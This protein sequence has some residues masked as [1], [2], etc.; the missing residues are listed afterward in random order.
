MTRACSK[1]GFE[2]ADDIDFCARCGEY[3]RWELSGT[4]RLPPEEGPVDATRAAGSP[5]APQET[6]PYPVSE[7]GQEAAGQ[8]PLLVALRLPE[9]ESA[10]GEVA[11]T[12][13]AG[14][15]TNVIAFLRNQS[16]IVDNYDLSVE[17]L[18][19][20][21]WSIAPT[22]VY[23]VPY[24]A[25][26]GEYEQDVTITFHPPRTPEAE[27]R[28]W[29]IRVVAT[30]RANA[31]PAGGAAATLEIR[32]YH[33]LEAEMRPEIASGRR[34]ARY[35]IALRNR[36]NAAV[37]VEL[38]TVD[39]EGILRFKFE[40]QRFSIEPGRRNGSIFG[41]SAAKGVLFG[42]SIQR[43][44]E[45]ASTVTGSDVGAPPKSG[46]FV[47]KAWVP[48]WAIVVG[49]LLV[50]GAIAAYLLWPHPVT[51]PSLKG[52]EVF[53]AQQLLDQAGLELGNRSEKA[54]NGARPGTILTQ[55]PQAG[56]E[57]DSGDEVSILVAVATD[58][59]VV[60]DI[61]GLSLA[62]ADEALS[63]V[64]FSLGHAN[65][66]P[67][68]P[69]HSRIVS[70][71]PVAGAV[72]RKGRGVDVYFG[73]EGEG[74]DGARLVHE[75]VTSA[76]DAEA[77]A[78]ATAGKPAGGNVEVP[79]L[80]ESTRAR[81]AR[82]LTQASLTPVA[83]L[84]YTADV[85]AGQLVT[86]SPEAGTSV[87]PWTNVAYF[88][89]APYPELAFEADGDL[90]TMSGADGT[91]TGTLMKSREFEGHLAWNPTGTTLAFRRGTT[92]QGGQIWLVARDGSRPARQLTSAGFDDRRPAFSPDGNVIAFVRGPLEQQPPATRDFDLC[93]VKARGGEPACI[94]DEAN[95]VHR[96]TWAPDGH[97]ILVTSARAGHANQELVE[98][99]SL[100]PSS[101]QPGDWHVSGP[102]TDAL[103]SA[104][105][106]DSVAAAALSPDGTRV[107]LSVNWG[108]SASHLVIA[109]R[110]GHLLS[111]P[112]AFPNI[113]SCELSWR[114]DGGELAV[115]QRGDYC[116]D[117]GMIVR[118]NPRHPSTVPLTPSGHD[119]GSPAWSPS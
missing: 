46:T 18:P 106:E 57:V 1:C 17:G 27:A 96:P 113:R 24:G 59:A 117:K 2:S 114:S 119:A 3:L 75:A 10:A 25:A 83:G 61:V 66:E 111:Q 60:P 98:Y 9:E 4:S 29:P 63:E 13:G 105:P 112:K 68:D 47:Q 102:I 116:R 37:D 107:A 55:S 16:G 91:R 81:A 104:R 100:K 21:W 71:I 8:V 56:E 101:P 94:R 12:V 69:E 50:I 53:A 79:D 34:R 77:R 62:A 93:L 11:T 64:G 87:A 74:G 41:V 86:Q 26:S 78:K 32:P 45:I 65:P 15:T 115:V 99:T 103:H 39:P 67:A 110:N 90:F 40:K 52:K 80:S 23:L 36:G 28:V 14:S 73:V 89:A 72:G 54:T 84:L 30:S 108:T 31:A 22:T 97:T 43:R 19:E 35:A 38:S 49:A 82:E 7:S 33:E 76:A 88:Y 51:V 42:R 85:P 5:R 48:A 118:F 6:T 95:A 92:N 58:T 109:N 44:F 70:Q 20:D